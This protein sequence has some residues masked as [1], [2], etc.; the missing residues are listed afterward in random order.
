[1][2]WNKAHASMAFWNQNKT[3]DHY[4][5]NH[6]HWNSGANHLKQIKEEAGF[7]GVWS[8]STLFSQ[9]CLSEYLS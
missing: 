4:E 1:M 6:R 8:R 9:A 3:S 7:C 5:L 2:L